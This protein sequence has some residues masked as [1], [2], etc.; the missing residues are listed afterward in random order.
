MMFVVRNCVRNYTTYLP[1]ITL[2]KKKSVYGTIISRHI[3]SSL[4]AVGPNPS[5][6]KGLESDSNAL[7][8]SSTTSL[9]ARRCRC[10]VYASYL[11]KLKTTSWNISLFWWFLA[12]NIIKK[13]E[14]DDF[15]VV[16]LTLIL[17]LHYLV[18]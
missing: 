2:V 10:N 15:S 9:K 12:R 5:P 8:D 17:L 4:S 6:K 1:K 7:R 11:R 18:K 3:A 13:L 14:V 16:H